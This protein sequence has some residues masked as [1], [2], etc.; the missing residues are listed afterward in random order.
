MGQTIMRSLLFMA[1]G[2]LMGSILFGHLL[3]KYFKNIEIE[4]ISEDKNPGTA[5][6]MKYAGIPLGMLC[7]ILDMGKG[8]LPLMW[9]RRFVK[10][11]SLMFAGVMAAPVIGHAFPWGRYKQGGKAIAVSFGVLL[12]VYRYSRSV[13]LVALLY[14]FMSVVIVVRPNER[15]S[16]YTF[17]IFGAVS[18][19]SL[20]FGS[21]PGI[22]VGN[23]LIAAVVVYKNWAGACFGREEEQD[24]AKPRL[25]MP[26]KDFGLRN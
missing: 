1:V 11:V 4:E 3:P 23:I 20:F 14:I 22:C 6:V 12:G 25:R 10:P 24:K 21:L 2:Y 5:N 19:A 16:V 26:W 7:L 17:L 13:W 15:R 18:F 8:Y 9:A